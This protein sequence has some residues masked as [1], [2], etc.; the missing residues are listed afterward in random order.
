MLVDKWNLLGLVMS[1]QKLQNC[2]RCV[3]YALLNRENSKTKAL[4]PSHKRISLDINM[5]VRSVRRGLNELIEH[6][7]IYKIKKGSPGKATDYKINY[8]KLTKLSV[9][10]AN[11]V[12]KRGSE[13]AD[14]SINKSINKSIVKKLVSQVAINSNANVKLY[15]SGKRKAYNDPENVAHRIYVKTN[16]ISKS[17]AYLELKRSNN[18]D[19]KVRADEFAKHLGCLE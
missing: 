8:D 18:W 4:F 6:E 14:Q 1:K 11:S 16:S 7:F 9:T 5:S 13:M 3:M 2:T 12:Q 10:Q 15:K 19:D 17:E